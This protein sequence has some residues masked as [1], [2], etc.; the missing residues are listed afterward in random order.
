MG[1]SILQAPG[2]KAA[3]DDLAPS[4]VRKVLQLE[5]ENAALNAKLNDI[6]NKVHTTSPRQVSHC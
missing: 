4:L 1:L 2:C 6:S 3:A 5:A